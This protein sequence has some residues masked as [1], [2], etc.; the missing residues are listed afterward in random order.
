M[1]NVKCIDCYGYEQCPKE[2]YADDDIC[3]FYNDKKT[4]L[5]EQGNKQN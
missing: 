3:E 2:P 5:A 4:D 1:A